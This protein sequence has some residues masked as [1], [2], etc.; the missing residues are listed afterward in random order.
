MEIEEGLLER[1]EIKIENAWKKW[2]D[3]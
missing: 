2:K 3:L 1:R